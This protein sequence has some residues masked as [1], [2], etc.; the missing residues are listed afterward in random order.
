MTFIYRKTIIRTKVAFS[1]TIKCTH[2]ILIESLNSTEPNERRGV[3]LSEE[4]K[5]LT[6]EVKCKR[7]KKDTVEWRADRIDTAG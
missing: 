6:V 2:A 5:V 3:M 1:G 7:R 4:I